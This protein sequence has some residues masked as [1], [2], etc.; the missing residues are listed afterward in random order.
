[1]EFSLALL[2]SCAHRASRVFRLSLATTKQPLSLA[3]FGLPAFQALI[4]FY[5]FSLAHHGG[6]LAKTD[7]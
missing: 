2:H 5:F 7:E 4:F 3:F 1:M 6:M